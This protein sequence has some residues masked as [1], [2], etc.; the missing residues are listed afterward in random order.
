[1]FSAD[2]DR[3]LWPV[4][5]DLDA[6]QP[7]RRAQEGGDEAALAIEDNDRLET[8]VVVMGVEQPQLLAAV[9][10]IEGVYRTRFFGH[11]A[12]LAAACMVI[13]EAIHFRQFRLGFGSR[14]FPGASASIAE[15]QADLD[16]WLRQYNEVRT[17]Q[18]RW[19]YGKTPMQTFLD[20]LPMARKK[21]LDQQSQLV[22]V[23]NAVEGRRLCL[24]L[25]HCPNVDRHRQDTDRAG[26]NGI[27]LR[28]RC[29]RRGW[30]RAG[31][32]RSRCRPVGSVQAGC[33]AIDTGRAPSAERAVTASGEQG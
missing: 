3:H 5:A 31:R 27:G 7:L 14:S 18:G 2:Q 28:G 32:Q 15:L 24:W 30:G 16:Q 12:A 6:L 21:L 17:H 13:V 29:T 10:R 1:M 33:A 11:K 19:C 26:N 25:R 9:H 4:G 23:A 22:A 20:S 8:V